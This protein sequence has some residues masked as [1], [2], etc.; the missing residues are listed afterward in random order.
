MKSL[1]IARIIIIFFC[2]DKN[3]NNNINL[4]FRSY[5]VNVTGILDSFSEWV[6]CL[7]MVGFFLFNSHVMVL[8]LCELIKMAGNSDGSKNQYLEHHYKAYENDNC[9]LS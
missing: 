8:F 2:C 7:W 9:L 5:G 6:V 3:K 4:I 1:F